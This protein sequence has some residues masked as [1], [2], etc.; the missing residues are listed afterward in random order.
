MS[1]AD[2]PDVQEA[3]PGLRKKFKKRG[4]D[5]KLLSAATGAGVREVLFE[6]YA[7]SHAEAP[8]VTKAPPAKK[9]RTRTAK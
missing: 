8:P 6:L 4:F 3:Y 2:L 1:K 9:K 7:L 5:L